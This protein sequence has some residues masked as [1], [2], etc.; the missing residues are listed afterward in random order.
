MLEAEKALVLT[1]VQ[2]ASCL[3]ERHHFP[4]PLRATPDARLLVHVCRLRGYREPYLTKKFLLKAK[5]MSLREAGVALETLTLLHWEV[6]ALHWALT[7]AGCT[8]TTQPLPTWEL[9]P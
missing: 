3:P 9:T 1:G 7:S 8:E 2:P 6:L 5:V 4:L